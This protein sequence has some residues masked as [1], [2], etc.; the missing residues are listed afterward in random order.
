MTTTDNLFS[1]KS[2]KEADKGESIKLTCGNTKYKCHLRTWESF[3]LQEMIPHCLQ[4]LSKVNS[5]VAV[6]N[7]K[8]PS[9]F[10]VFRRTLSR[11]L[12][13]VWNQIVEET[14]ND[15]DADIAQSNK[16][17]MLCVKQFIAAHSTSSDRHEWLRCFEQVRN[18]GT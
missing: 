4:V 2:S 6:E 7:H 10:K 5:A 15:D 9:Y 8:G 16:N 17:F 18:Q 3:D 1:F 13:P 14:R 11:I 12:E